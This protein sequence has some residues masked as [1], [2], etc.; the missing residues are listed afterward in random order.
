MITQP[1]FYA[2]IFPS[3]FTLW[4]IKQNIYSKK[5]KFASHNITTHDLFVSRNAGKINTDQSLHLLFLL[6]LK[7]KQ[8]QT[9]KS[10]DCKKTFRVSMLLIQLALNVFIPCDDWKASYRWYSVFF[11]IAMLLLFEIS[12]LNMTR[13]LLIPKL[14]NK[15]VINYAY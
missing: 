3:E 13:I 15:A 7:R 6:F 2:A 10:K 12:V 9:F 4:H 5:T 11:L 1:T 8:S 14:Q